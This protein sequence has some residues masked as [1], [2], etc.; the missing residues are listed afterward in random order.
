MPDDVDVPTKSDNLLCAAS[1]APASKAPTSNYS[2]L[3]SASPLELKPATFS[4]HRSPS[5][6]MDGARA[7]YIQSEHL[8][9]H[10]HNLESPLPRPH[11]VNL[12][13][14][15]NYKDEE[16]A[17]LTPADH[18]SST[19]F[20]QQTGS[21]IITL[22]LAVKSSALKIRTAASEPHF[23]AFCTHGSLL[24][25]FWA[26][27]LS[28]SVCTCKTLYE[29]RIWFL[30]PWVALSCVEFLLSILIGYAFCRHLIH[31]KWGMNYQFLLPIL[32]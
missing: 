7:R 13:M 18:E 12:R 16:E 14:R 3:D 22:V 11:S 23:L 28:E 27:V 20:W 30:I 19:P 24:V 32:V 9:A 21:W 5:S 29:P 4:K 2:L 31:G 6:S 10:E 8:E 17:L 1:Y 25:L 15:I 26:V